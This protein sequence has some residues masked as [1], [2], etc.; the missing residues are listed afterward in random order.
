VNGHFMLPVN[1]D[2]ERL[3]APALTVLGFEL[4]SCAFVSEA[5]RKTLRVLIDA[6]TG[7]TVE[8]CSDASRQINAVLDA[9]ANMTAPYDLEVSSPGL[10]RPL[11]TLAHYQRFV[12]SQVKIKLREP[13]A[14]RRH[15]TGQLAAAA[16]NQITL[17]VD[18]NTVALALDNIEKANVVP[19][20]GP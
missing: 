9:E 2:I 12:G 3:I 19:D 17:L 15:F 18:G 6:P 14:D 13:L 11:I 16:E 4:V 20:I 10:D 1:A 7:V 8:N 5:G